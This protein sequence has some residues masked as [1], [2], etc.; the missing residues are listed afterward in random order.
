MK[1]LPN[2]NAK[3]DIE[4]AELAKKELSTLK[5]EL[6]SALSMQKQRL[7]AALSRKR[8]WSYDSWKSVFLENQL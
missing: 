1:S 4:K 8:Y 7:E 3:D 6:R 2:P 5:K